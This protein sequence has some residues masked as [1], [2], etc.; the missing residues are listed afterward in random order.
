[1]MRLMVVLAIFEGNRFPGL[2]GF[3]S[4]VCVQHNTQPKGSEKQGRPG[5]EVDV[6]EPAT[7]KINQFLTCQPEY[8]Q[9][10]ERLGSCQVMEHLTMM[11][12]SM[13]FECEPLFP[14]ST[15]HQPNIIYV[16]SVPR[17]GNKAI[18]YSS[19]RLP[20]QLRLALP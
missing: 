17:T 12:S 4:L 5:C 11:M 15:L 8:L 19:G 16:I 6:R 14:T 3:C 9:P 2:P 1:M 20:N 10:C 13:L 18:P 7:A